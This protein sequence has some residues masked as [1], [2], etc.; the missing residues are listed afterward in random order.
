MATHFQI[1][2][3]KSYQFFNTDGT[4]TEKIKKHLTENCWY[5]TT[6]TAEVYIALRLDMDDPESLT[7]KKINNNTSSVTPSQLMVE[8]E[9]KSDL[10]SLNRDVNILYVVKDEKATYKWFQSENDFICIGRDTE[11]I[12]LIDGGRASSNK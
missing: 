2:K 10:Y 11:N 5:M 8:V 3:G 6:D 7:L 4:L 9:T 12:T 1:I